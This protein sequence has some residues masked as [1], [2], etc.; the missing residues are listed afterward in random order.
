MFLAASLARD[1]EKIAAIAPLLAADLRHAAESREW[2]DAAGRYNELWRTRLVARERGPGW[3]PATR[4]FGGGRMLL[5]ETAEKERFQ[6]TF[7]TSLAPENGA[8]A[9]GSIWEPSVGA[10]RARKLKVGSKVFTFDEE[11][12]FLSSDGD[13]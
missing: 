13:G 8:L 9:V 2:K 5:V 1:W 3:T 6:F 11:G 10:A 4:V 7:D 12:V